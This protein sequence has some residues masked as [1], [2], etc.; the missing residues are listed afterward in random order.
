MWSDP[1]GAL[2]IVNV[3][4][5]GH[6][7]SCHWFPE[8][9]E[10]AYDPLTRHWQLATPEDSLPPAID[11]GT[12]NSFWWSS[13]N[14]DSSFVVSSA[15]QRSPTVAVKLFDSHTL[16]SNTLATIPTSILDSFDSTCVGQN[17]EDSSCSSKTWTGEQQEAYLLAAYSP[18]SRF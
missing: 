2:A 9:R 4:H 7:I 8:D 13:H 1:D 10:I 18:I 15:A 12:F 14:G 16:T 3:K 5:G 6:R 11:G 17:I